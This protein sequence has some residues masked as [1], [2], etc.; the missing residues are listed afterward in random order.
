MLVPQ[1]EWEGRREKKGE[2]ETVAEDRKNRTKNRGSNNF[3]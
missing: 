2:L 1:N 3:P